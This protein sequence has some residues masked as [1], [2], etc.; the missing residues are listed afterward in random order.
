MRY[1][2]RSSIQ[3]VAEH[4]VRMKQITYDSQTPTRLMCK[5]DDSY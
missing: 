4:F 5:I 3:V 2:A 1:Q